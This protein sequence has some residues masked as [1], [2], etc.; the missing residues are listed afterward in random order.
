MKGHKPYRL[1][2]VGFPLTHSR[3]PQLQVAAL[4]SLGLEGEYRLYPVLPG[5]Q[6]G[7][8]GL[9]TGLRKGE[10]D[11]LNVTLPHKQAVIPWLDELSPVAKSI[12]AVN[13]IFRRGG[14]LI[15]E[16]TDAPSFWADLEKHFPEDAERMLGKVLVLGAGGGARAVVFALCSRG[17][18]VT[19]AARRVDQA[20]ELVRSL[21]DVPGMAALRPE[22][23]EAGSLKHYLNDVRLIVNTT[24]VGMAPEVDKS[25]WP[26]G[27]SFPRATGVY[28]LVYN[29]GETLLVRQARAAGLRAATGMGMLVEQAALSF[30]IWTGHAPSRESMWTT[31]EAE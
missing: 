4:R 12:G 6:A 30:E 13:T 14:R 29:P 15:G 2:L 1:G 11:G 9:L 16:N 18:Q 7:L 26:K 27:L 3:S 10:L 21:K 5:D 20:V 8:D 28:D 23:L 25:P 17:W 31:V 19:L 22:L 24:P